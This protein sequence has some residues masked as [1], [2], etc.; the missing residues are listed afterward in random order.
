MPEGDTVWR[1]ARELHR[2]LAGK[3]LTRC[4][5]RVPRFATVDFTGDTVQ[6]AV[7]RGKHLLIRGGG[8]DGWDIHSHLK[9]EGLWHV[10]AR[11][12]KWRRPAF[13]A[14]CILETADAV[15][16]G[17]ELGFLRVIPRAEEDDAVGYLGPDLLGPDWDPEEALRRLREQ[18]ERPIGLALLDQRNLAGIGNVYRCELCFLAGVH[19]LTP[20]GEVPNLP[21]MVELSKKLLEANKERS[22]RATTGQL[23]GNTLWVYGRSRRGCLRCGTPV[24]LEQLGDKETELRELYYCP[25]CQ[26]R[27]EAP[28]GTALP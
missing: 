12:E 10:Y 18:P 23:R 9:M 11:G 22:T 2:A 19:P 13:K 14:R 6:E 4:D 16:V 25:H 7:S 5:I 1:A 21:R 28:A 24:A 20:V 8:D 27:L 15:V 3:T 26:P 17:F